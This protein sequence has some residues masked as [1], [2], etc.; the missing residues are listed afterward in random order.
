MKLILL[1]APGAG[2]G[3]QAEFICE[4]LAIPVIG[5][6]NLIREAIRN[7]TEIGRKVKEYVGSGGLV[8][9]EMVIAMIQ[10]RIA[11]D[12]CN[13]GYILDGFPRT[14]PQAEALERMGVIIDKVI[15]Y[16]VEDAVIVERLTGRRVCKACGSSYHT[17]HK[18]TKEPDKC[19]KCG[20]EVAVRADDAPET[21]QNRLRVYHEQT[22]PLED[23]YRAAGKLVV[24]KGQHTVA[25]ITRL[26]LAELEA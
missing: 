17:A 1:G 19:D 13:N 15:D 4:K 16:D 7:D 10:E 3:T 20:G 23:Y 22:K 9:D 2:K 21:V 8:P 18:P 14:V 5:T 26:T 24:I 11:Q 12:D 25:E 6:G